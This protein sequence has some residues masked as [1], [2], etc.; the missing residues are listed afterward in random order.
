VLVTK[1]RGFLEHIVTLSKL[2]Q[3]HCVPDLTLA[4]LALPIVSLGS[5]DYWYLNACEAHGSE[6]KTWG[7]D[8]HR[9][10]P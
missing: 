6:G 8:G 9:T 3:N 10:Y 7:G 4:M 5:C 1:E 2:Y